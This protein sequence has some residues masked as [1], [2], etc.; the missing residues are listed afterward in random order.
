MMVWVACKI[1][2]FCL[3]MLVGY[4]LA[5]ALVAEWRRRRRLRDLYSWRG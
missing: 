1:A 2:R 3:L 5:H 4:A